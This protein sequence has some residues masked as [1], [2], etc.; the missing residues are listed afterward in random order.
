[1]A[2]DNIVTFF[3]RF[4]TQGR[5]DRDLHGT[6]A[7]WEILKQSGSWPAA[8]ISGYKSSIPPVYFC[9]K[10]WIHVWFMFMYMNGWLFHGIKVGKPTIVPWILMR[11]F[12]VLRTNRQTIFAHLFTP[13]PIHTNR[14]HRKKKVKFPS[15][16]HTSS[17]PQ[18][19]SK[20]EGKWDPFFQENPDCLAR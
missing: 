15:R 6:A 2:C 8:E 13:I 4:F 17:S 10:A 11:F 9:I 16:R 5:K 19:G 3:F 1:M 12:E 20:L 14:S 7:F 18:K